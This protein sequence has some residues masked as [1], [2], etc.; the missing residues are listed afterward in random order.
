LRFCFRRSCRYDEISRSAS[1]A[2]RRLESQK[3]ASD[4]GGEQR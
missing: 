3:C 1:S 2:V 4:C